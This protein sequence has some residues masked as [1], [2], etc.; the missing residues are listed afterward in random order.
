MAPA[1]LGGIVESLPLHCARA[2]KLHLPEKLHQSSAR[3]DRPELNR[4][5]DTP[6]RKVWFQ[7]WDS[8]ITFEKSYLARLNYVHR[9]AVHHGL[10]AD[11]AAYKWCSAAWFERTAEHAFFRTVW[12]FP[13]DRLHVA[14]DF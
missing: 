8:P 2:F 7:Y 1:S 10:V 13:C 4:L 11:P 6:G 9:N 3:K 5:D 14:D 12:E